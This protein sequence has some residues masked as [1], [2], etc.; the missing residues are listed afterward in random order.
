[1]GPRKR[2]KPNPKQKT[3]S[4]S[5]PYARNNTVASK[6]EGHTDPSPKQSSSPTDN[7]EQIHGTH[8]EGSST[9]RSTK[10][11]YGG[12]WPKG[13]KAT[14]VTQVAKESISA[15]AGLASEA[16]ATAR[17]HT[18]PLSSAPAKSP[19]FQS[20]GSSSRSLPLAATTTKLNITSNAP[21]SAKGD[22]KV[23]RARE[24]DGI[25]TKKERADASLTTTPQIVPTL[26]ESS[27]NSSLT[28]GAIAT[29]PNRQK[30]HESKS[31]GEFAGW[32]SWFAKPE[33]AK[34][35]STSVRN[36]DPKV[37]EYNQPEDD[38]PPETEVN[39]K[40][41]EVP[42][43]PHPKS[44]GTATS[45]VE[46]AQNVRR[47]WLQIWNNVQIKPEG[48][49]T[50]GESVNT[51]TNKSNSLTQDAKIANLT[52]EDVI[53]S[54]TQQDSDSQ[55]QAKSSGWAF[56]SRDTGKQKP[57]D[58]SG[59]LALALAGAPSQTCPE[60]DTLDDS[61]G[62]PKKLGERRGQQLPEAVG[63][64][65]KLEKT[66]GEKSKTDPADAS[67]ASSKEN[68]KKST[69]QNTKQEPKNLLLPTFQNTYDSARKPGVMQQ[70]GRWLPFTSQY[71]QSKHLNTAT[72]PPKIKVALAIGVHGFFPAPLVRS[73]LG[74][75]T[76]T[77]I[78]FAN[79]AATAIQKWTEAQG[80]SCE[81]EKVALEGEGKI[82]ER[83][84]LLWKLLLNWIDKISKADFVFVACHSQGCPVAMMLVAKLISFGCVSSARIGVCAMAGI[85]LGPFIDY[86]SRWIGGT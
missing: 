57:S 50:T 67:D 52:N 16:V 62:I 27:K 38:E 34:G 31:F 11:W 61:Q 6:N 69:R 44:L 47:S 53:A 15:A 45:T 35:V 18:P 51:T 22:E 7:S 60:K 77:S 66:R 63:D 40:L 3:N 74:Q 65:D 82:A 14:P 23:G 58:S 73:F 85:N 84:N 79:S 37:L 13:N 43:P 81:I 4:N 8:N 55:E 21:T 78:R 5:E 49:P 41:P 1:M 24:E 68:I 56:W 72:I 29:D 33:P 46:S 48:L 12:T 39:S 20:L 70:L 83:I 54:E 25:A 76:G 75:P 32:L 19:A 17:A 80:Y 86:K 42:S 9:P 64:V 71:N 36:N 30:A 2:S 10:S 26:Q 59:E 28:G